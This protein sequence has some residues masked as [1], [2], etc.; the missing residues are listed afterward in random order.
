MTRS[1]KF[2]KE[3]RKLPH[4]STNVSRQRIL[5]SLLPASCFFIY[6]LYEFWTKWFHTFP[7]FIMCAVRS[8]EKLSYTECLV[9]TFHKARSIA[10]FLEKEANVNTYFGGWKGLSAHELK[11]FLIF[12]YCTVVEN[13]LSPVLLVYFLVSEAMMCLSFPNSSGK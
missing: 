6:T 5:N 12:S 9:G 11:Y 1:S 2:Q 7:L 3:N 8:I 13:F 10:T 4:C